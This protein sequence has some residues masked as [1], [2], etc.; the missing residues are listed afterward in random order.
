MRRIIILTLFLS[1]CLTQAQA[2]YRED[3]SDSIVYVSNV[4]KLLFEEVKFAY[5]T[6][7]L[8][9]EQKIGKVFSLN[10][11][12]SL[13]TRVVAN[14]S[15]PNERE[16]EFRFTLDWELRYYHKMGSRINNGLQANN[17]TGRYFAIGTSI[18]FGGA[19]GLNSKYRRFS[20][21]YG[22]Q[23]KISK[24]EYLDVG[25]DLQYTRTPYL[26]DLDVERNLNAVSISN[27]TRYGFLIAKKDRS[28]KND[29]N[30]VFNYFTSRKSA[31]RINLNRIIRLSN[32]RG[33]DNF[34]VFAIRP[35]I[36][37]ERKIADSVFSLDQELSSSISFGN[38]V[39]QGAPLELFERSIRYRIAGKY[40]YKMKKKQLEGQSGNNLSGA[41]LFLRAS[42]TQKPN[43]TDGFTE[44]GIGSQR[45]LDR[46]FVGLNLYGRIRTY[47]S[48][49]F[50]DVL[51]T[52]ISG[53]I[54][55][56]YIIK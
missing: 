19:T 24:R 11:L 37:Y 41:Y 6:N 10:L 21:R 36:S 28:T 15:L 1:Y 2:Q 47:G 18:V 32:V 43:K 27:Y 50:F 31:W 33:V 9:I 38:R 34:F 23:R 55:V 14:D 30:I 25:L 35:N 5:K 48:K 7:P 8:G 40:F 45:E 52:P 42:H 4:D 3:V 22:Y 26:D 53:E 13:N 16:V 17:I 56:S 51:E 54:T 20:T 49:Y 46:V 39:T 44:F 12:P 29:R